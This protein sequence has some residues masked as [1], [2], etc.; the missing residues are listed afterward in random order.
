MPIGVALGKNIG[1]WTLNTS[2]QTNPLSGSYLFSNVVNRSYVIMFTI[3]ASCL[4]A[5][6]LYST[7]RLQWKTNDKQRSITEVSCC[8]VLPD[9][10][11]KEHVVESVKTMTK[12]RAMNRR[13][14]L[15]MFMISMLFYTFQRDEKPM[16]YLYTQYKFNWNTETYSTFKTFQSS[17]YVIIMLT[18]IP[19]MSKVLGFKDTVSFVWCVWFE[20][21][22][23]IDKEGGLVQTSVRKTLSHHPL[24]IQLTNWI[25]LSLSFHRR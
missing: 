13:A 1:I 25:F 20:E 9:F 4:I 19:L 18:G 15:W 23:V 6:I 3:N 24:R 16:T 17:A 11:D 2:I 14:Y 5:A 21:W 22:V 12:K 10:F 8:G 7:F